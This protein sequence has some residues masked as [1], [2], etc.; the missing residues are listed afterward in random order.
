MLQRDNIELA[1]ST[2]DPGDEAS[3]QRWKETTGTRYEVQV[4]YFAALAQAHL[5]NWPELI[6]QIKDAIHWHRVLC[7]FDAHAI[8][9]DWLAHVHAPP[10]Y[11]LQRTARAMKMTERV[12]G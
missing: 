3:V 9:P 6:P 1:A 8:D 7:G 12:K 10:F 11:R 4:A 2:F 5:E